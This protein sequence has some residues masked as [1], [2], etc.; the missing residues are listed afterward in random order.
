MVAIGKVLLWLGFSVWGPSF[1]FI[2]FWINSFFVDDSK[3]SRQALQEVIPSQITNYFGRLFVVAL[4]L[5]I[6][7]LII[8]CQWFYC[9]HIRFTCFHISNPNQYDPLLISNVT[10]VI[11][12]QRNSVCYCLPISTV[13]VDFPSLCV[14]SIGP[15]VDRPHLSSPVF[16]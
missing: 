16:V 11:K 12:E 5:S 10:Q 4:R 1:V 6:Q 8:L 2:G 9:L 14:L 7:P 13:I 15:W 3:T